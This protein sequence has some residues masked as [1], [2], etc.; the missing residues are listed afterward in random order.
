MTTH[1]HTSF[2]ANYDGSIL[3]Q[4]NT[5]MHSHP[6]EGE[7]GYSEAD[8]NAWRQMH[9]EG[10]GIICDF[11][12]YTV[13]DGKAKSYSYDVRYNHPDKSHWGNNC[14]NIIT[15]FVCLLFPL[16][17]RGQERFTYEELRDGFFTQYVD[18]NSQKSLDSLDMLLWEN[19]DSII[20]KR[21]RSKYYLC[22]NSSLHK[23][24]DITL[25]IST[26]AYIT[27]ENEDGYERHVLYWVEPRHGGDTEAWRKQR[28]ALRKKYG[29]VILNDSTVL[30][31]V[32]WYSGEVNFL[33][34]PFLYG[35]QF[36]S[37]RLCSV[38]LLGGIYSPKDNSQPAFSSQW[39][40]GGELR[41]IIFHIMSMQGNGRYI[42]QLDG[43]ENKKLERERGLCLFSKEVSRYIDV[44]FLEKDYFSREYTVMLRLDETL[45]AHLYVLQP[46]KLTTEDRLLLSS[47]S[48]AVNQQPAGTFSGYWCSRGLYPAI[49]LKMRLSERA[50]CTFEY[51]AE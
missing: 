49:F 3:L 8:W 36:V 7:Q 16:L 32:K 12:V 34:S 44:S 38:T 47:V 15:K 37:N 2:V 28:K 31:P 30:I 9:S 39:K 22:P 41:S 51:F 27:E 4:Y 25:P 1:S 46:E 6:K 23:V 11:G 50:G 18:K 20:L 33:E 42:S 45:K 24:G 40:I 17:I 26:F 21:D 13:S 5:Y 10:D 19:K 35:N 14:M 29:C 43:E 48:T